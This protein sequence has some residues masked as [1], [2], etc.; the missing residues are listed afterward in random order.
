MKGCIASFHILHF[1]CKNTASYSKVYFAFKTIILKKWCVF[2]EN[3]HA[4]NDH[5]DLVGA[6]VSFIQG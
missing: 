5:A 3:G 1:F 6:G 4:E 2:L